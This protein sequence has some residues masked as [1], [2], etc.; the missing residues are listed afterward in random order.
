MRETFLCAKYNRKMDIAVKQEEA[1][2]DGQQQKALEDAKNAHE[3]GLTTEQIMKITGL[4]IEQ[5]KEI[6]KEEV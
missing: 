2:K 1:F 6:V 5:I 3:L 4:T